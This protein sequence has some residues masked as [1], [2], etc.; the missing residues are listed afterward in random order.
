M[1]GK[2]FNPFPVV[3][4]NV[5]QIATLIFIAVA[6]AP[7]SSHGSQWD[8]KQHSWDRN[9]EVYGLVPSTTNCENWAIPRS[10]GY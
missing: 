10:S 2:L 9:Q 7:D 6:N 5:G 1:T 3:L 4:Q 8:I